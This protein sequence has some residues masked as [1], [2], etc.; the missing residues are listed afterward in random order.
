MLKNSN[1]IRLLLERKKERKNVFISH[2]TNFHSSSIRLLLE[3]KKK[4]TM[5]S[6][7][8]MMAMMAPNRRTAPYE[9]K[10]SNISAKVH[11]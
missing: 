11:I 2:P 4:I 7:M 10:H 8:A 6:E 5:S 9:L 3:R 1:A